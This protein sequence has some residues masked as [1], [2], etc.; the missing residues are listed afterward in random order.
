VLVAS[1][2]LFADCG[3]PPESLPPVALVLEA[4]GGKAGPVDLVVLDLSG[5]EVLRRSMGAADQALSSLHPATAQVAFWRRGASGSGHELVVW[6][7]ATNVLKVLGTYDGSLVSSP[8]WSRDGTEVVSLVTST[9]ISFMP[10]A[11]FDGTATISITSVATGQSRVLHSDRVFLPAFAD[12]TV[13][14]GDSLSGDMKYVVVDSQNGQVLREFG[15]AG[16]VGSF[17]TA[18]P[19]V[20]VLFRETA[21]PGE[22]TLHAFNA[23]SGSELSRLGPGLAG[24]MVSWPGRTEVAF[25]VAGDLKAYDYGKNTT[26]VAGRLENAVAALGFDPAGRVL[27]AWTQTEP[28]YGTFTVEGDRLTSAFQ[29]IPRDPSI[30]GLALGLVRV[31]F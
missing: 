14:S 7:I 8:L 28:F 17:P 3:T 1:A 20:I 16:A 2:A 19:D 29:M 5:R 23:R 21:V 13:V 26:R 31:K 22:V 10:G 24:P 6:N 4:D 9:P 27:L 11:I 12:G 18:D 15:L 25:V 30:S